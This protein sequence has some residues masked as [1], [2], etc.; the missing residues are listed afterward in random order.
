M[1]FAARRPTR[2]ASTASRCGVSVILPCFNNGPTVA[3]CLEAL[4]G[5]TLG[6][7]E[8]VMVDSSPGDECE[9]IVRGRFP[10]VR[11]EHVPTRLLPHAARNR[12]AERAGGELLAFTDPDTYAHPDWLEKLVAR[13]RQS[14]HLVVGAL[15]C[16][17]RRWS[18]V[19]NH[20]CKFSKWLPGGR[21]RPVDN[22]PT[23]NLLCP[24]ALFDELGRFEADLVHGDTAFSWTA[25]A[26]GHT[27]CFAPDAIVVHHHLQGVRELLHERYGRGVLYG[28]MRAD[29]WADR[30]SILLLYLV[31]SFLPV[32]LLRI[33]ALTTGHCARARYLGRLAAT[34]PI[35]ILGHAAAL[36]G[37]CTTYTRRLATRRPNRGG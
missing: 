19:G 37:E 1:A 32:R 35:V 33:L 28:E 21:P 18:D 26:R 3:A 22:A 24:H 23:A 2:T 12:G 11:Y 31:V 13:H 14:G 10:E 8:V 36:L 25:R 27:L 30:R 7:F 15:A 5:Q 9:T 34:H 6:G 4:R 20:I 17:G 16:Y 29:R